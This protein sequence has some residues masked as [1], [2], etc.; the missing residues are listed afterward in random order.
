MN[1]AVYLADGHH[2][3]R[4]HADVLICAVFNR[5][6]ASGFSDNYRFL[7]ELHPNALQRSR[8]RAETLRFLCT[9][10]QKL[11][12][13]AGECVQ[14]P[15]TLFPAPADVPLDGH[16]RSADSLQ[17]QD[18]GKGLSRSLPELTVLFGATQ[19]IP[20]FAHQLP[21]PPQGTAP[22]M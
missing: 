21:A 15:P 5:S 12:A 2:W 8:M 18:C 13:K 16:A 20:Y 4:F 10:D 6:R 14:F 19:L 9:I 3:C 11:A 22:P 17:V 1:A 7:R